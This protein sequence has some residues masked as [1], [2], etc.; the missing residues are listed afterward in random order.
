MLPPRACQ[1]LRHVLTEPVIR[2]IFPLLF[3]ALDSGHHVRAVQAK[4][5]LVMY[6]LQVAMGVK[7]FS[8]HLGGAQMGGAQMALPPMA[9]RRTA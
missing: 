6:H 7:P 1:V 4:R 3:G 2:L 9:T 5:V 8:H